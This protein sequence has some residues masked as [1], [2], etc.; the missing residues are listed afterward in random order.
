M[1]VIGIDLGTTTCEIAYIE[2]GKPVIIEDE[3]SRKIIPS[4]VGIINNEAKA[5]TFAYNNM[6][7]D[8]KNFTTEFKKF[9]GDKEK[10]VD[11]NNE[12]FTPLELSAILLKKLKEIAENHL[13]EEI[14]EAIITVPANFNSY[15]RQL[16]QQA[17]KLAG[18][19][20]ERLIN[21]PTAAAMAY[22]IENLEEDSKILVYDLGGGT[23]DVTV[24]EMFCGILEVKA[25]RGNNSLGGVDFDN[26]I[27]NHLVKSI[28][29]IEKID[30][31]NDIKNEDEL[32]RVK[33]YL[34]KVSKKAKEELSSLESTIIDL[35]NLV[36]IGHKTI[37]LELFFT[38]KEF[39]NLVK[40]LVYQTRNT[41]EEA[42]KASSYTKEDI[43]IVLLIGGSTKV[44]LVKDFVKKIF[45][46]KIKD[47]INP[48]EAVALGAAV[49]AGIKT[50]QIDPKNSLIVTDKCNYNLGTSIVKVIGD[51]EI[52]DIFDL[53]IPVDSSIPCSGKN[54]YTTSFDN[55]STVD[56][57]VYE[58]Y[59]KFVYNN[60][61]IASF[62]IDGIPQA[63]KGVQQIGVEFRYNLNG[64]L[65]VGA[66]IISTQ[67]IFTQVITNKDIEEITHN[68]K[69]YITNKEKIIDTTKEINENNEIYSNKVFKPIE[70]VSQQS[71]FKQIIVDNNGD[72][73]E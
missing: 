58:G 60:T 59:D 32:L 23:F 69:K 41:V 19:Y 2:N 26:L 10:F 46:G 73:N 7:I 35:S 68:I 13:G 66:K 34:K 42:L 44:P 6:I 28:N 63:P 49:Q 16:T 48:D 18:L 53:L 27:L 39:E 20:V 71:I 15:Q 22:G 17:A 45:P 12:K 33:S 40:D 57:E 52:D 8:S 51:K 55:Q 11:L 72:I 67:Q 56:I 5:G 3:F 62:T 30:L 54:F 4:V 50:N 24:L 14:T 61:K 43:D 65:E 9:L 36:N 31:Y 70:Q 1:S 38:R 64:V 21:E 37:S 47:G 29:K 25:S